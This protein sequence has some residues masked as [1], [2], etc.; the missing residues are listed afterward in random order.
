MGDIADMIINGDLDSETGEYIGPGQGIPRT[1]QDRRRGARFRR[2]DFTQSD[3]LNGVIVYLHDK[4]IINSE[5][6]HKVMRSYGDEIGHTHVKKRNILKIA[7]K[8]Q[9]DFPRFV[10]WLKSNPKNAEQTQKKPG[11]DSGDQS[12]KICLEEEDAT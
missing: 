1:I 9:E 2:A 8:I 6:A 11:G 4:G 7:L 12:G 3:K 10:N 5:E